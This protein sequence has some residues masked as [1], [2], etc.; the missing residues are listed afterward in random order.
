MSDFPVHF[1]H[2]PEKPGFCC[3]IIGDVISGNVPSIRHLAIAAPLHNVDPRRY[4][5]AV[6]GLTVV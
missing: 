3:L 1:L 6:N 2:T 5:N 4:G